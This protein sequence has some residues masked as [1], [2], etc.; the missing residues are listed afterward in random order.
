MK[1]IISIL[2]ASAFLVSCNKI[3]GV[4]T[5]NKIAQYD[6]KIIAKKVILDTTFANF[7]ESAALDLYTNQNLA[8]FKSI[9]SATGNIQHKKL[10]LDLVKFIIHNPVILD[11][12]NEDRIQLIE[13]IRNYAK[14]SEFKI[15]HI[16]QMD[17][18]NS[19]TNNIIN[20][21]NKIS[22]NKN[23]IKSYAVSE[24]NIKSFKLSE[25]EA[26]DCL[27]LVASAVIGSYGKE[28]EKIMKLRKTLTL[29]A[30]ASAAIGI[31]AAASPWYKV[32]SVALSFAPCIRDFID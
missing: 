1:K 5:S 31:I 11:M 6:L 32:A 9:D 10:I 30:F 27:F 3:E 4:G 25:D 21:Y 24:R 29:E 13:E 28:L 2:I 26:Y 18:L 8:G 20:Y 17:Y 14:S 23:V 22:T 7:Y 16:K 15:N 12:N 19:K